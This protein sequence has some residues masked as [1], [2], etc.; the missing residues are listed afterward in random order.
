MRFDRIEAE[1]LRDFQ[2]NPALVVRIR[3]DRDGPNKYLYAV[4]NLCQRKGIKVS[5][6]TEEDKRR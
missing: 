1:L 4:L 3:A 5:L 6:A 2:A